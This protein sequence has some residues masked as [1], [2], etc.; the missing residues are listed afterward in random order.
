M[1]LLYPLGLLGLIGV[2]IL[3]LIYII[4]NKYTE[5]T[6][7]ST[8]LWTL[9]EKFL[10]KKRKPPKI[11]GLISLILQIAAVVAIS[12]SI[13]HPVFIFPGSAG[14]YCFI[15]DGSGS[16]NMETKGRTRFDSGKSKIVDIIK[17]SANGSV[18]TLVYASDTSVKTV[19][20]R[21]E[22]KDS[23][24]RMVRELTPSYGVADLTDALETAQRYFEENRALC[25]YLVTDKNYE[26]HENVNVVKVGGEEE[27]FA[28]VNVNY[29]FEEG[30]LAVKSAVISY[31]GNA[32]LD[33]QLYLDDGQT[34]VKTVTKSVEKQIAT[35]VDFKI[36]AED[37]SSVKVRIANDDAL[38]LDNECMAYNVK[39]ENAYATLLVSDTPFFLQSIVETLSGTKVETLTKAQYE[40]AAAA[41]GGTP[42]GYGLYIYD[43]VSPS[44]LPDDG[45]VWLFNQS[46]NIA[47]AEFSVRTEVVPEEGVL[48]EMT[49][50]SSSTARKLT[51]DMSGTDLYVS[52]YMKYGLYGTFTTLYSYKGQPLIFTGNNAYGNRE[53]VFAFSLHN[54]NFSVLGDFVIFMRNLLEF[55]F[56][57]V[58]EKTNYAC[59]ERLE[60]NV[61]PASSAIMIENPDGEVSYPASGVLA[62]EYVLDVPGSY[63]VTLTTADTESVYHVYAGIPEEERKVT[64]L[65]KDF[66]LQGEAGEGGLDG[67]YDD[68][69]VL[70]IVL[71][72]V[73][74]VDW[75]VYCYDKYQLR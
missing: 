45:A 1:K 52:R 6:V 40:E 30:V 34:P 5:Q 36:E 61:P 37:F 26:K 7:S 28:V 50:S 15:L 58:T 33:V 65:G 62:N 57:D 11:A 8:Y 12:F 3:I 54:S 47:E 60:I 67:K 25:T 9:S 35:V 24:I 70:F 38:E 59:G 68:L 73:F 48:L 66:S 31:E 19:Y 53:V 18:Y 2:P 71:G 51:A 64:A 20:E 32:T 21:T 43:S 42:K 55:S 17:D 56:P 22:D 13:A 69:I 23:A 75:V 39:S 46:Q 72:V 44:A 49:K 74:L 63:T 27:N 4:K 41:W 29:T 14:E 16:M 10:K